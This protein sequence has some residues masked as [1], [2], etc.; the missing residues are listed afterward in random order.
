MAFTSSRIVVRNLTPESFDHTISL[1]VFVCTFIRV[2]W[3][4]WGNLRKVG[5]KGENEVHRRILKRWWQMESTPQEMWTSNGGFCSGITVWSVQRRTK[6]PTFHWPFSLNVW[7]GMPNVSMTLC[8]TN[9]GQS[10][11]CTNSLLWFS[12]KFCV[13]MEQ[14]AT[15]TWMNTRGRH[16][17]EMNWQVCSQFTT[18]RIVL[19]RWAQVI[20]AMWLALR[21]HNS[22][23]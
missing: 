9:C 23:I 12:R 1:P 8:F 3:A 15:A 5:E 22:R 11:Q 21:S 10:N 16:V 14:Q 17:R 13:K 6:T 4:L 20:P 2:L 18:L 19:K 7:R